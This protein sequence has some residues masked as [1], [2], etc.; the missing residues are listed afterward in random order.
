LFYRIPYGVQ[1]VFWKLEEID[2]ALN[3]SRK[4]DKGLNAVAQTYSVPKATINRHFDGENV[5]AAENKDIIGSIS[6]I[7]QETEEELKKQ[8]FGV[9]R[10]NARNYA[11]QSQV[12]V[13]LSLYLTN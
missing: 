8:I 3:A 9:R 10:Q 2:R 12:K 13:K 4:G 7:P 6:D 5:V 1:Y 11:Y